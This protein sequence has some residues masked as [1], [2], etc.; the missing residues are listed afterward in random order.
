MKTIAFAA[1]TFVMGGAFLFSQDAALAKGPLDIE[2]D[3]PL[4]L[5][6]ETPTELDMSDFPFGL[7]EGT[8]KNVRMT[9]DQEMVI[10]DEDETF[11]MIYTITLPTLDVDK[12]GDDKVTIMFP[13][14][15]T[16]SMTTSAEGEDLQIDI[17]ATTDDQEMTFERDGERMNYS[18]TAGA[19]TL[20]LT[21]PQ[22]A[23]E[24]VDFE[25]TMG[26]KGLDVKGSGAAEQDWTDMKALDLSYDYTM[27]EITYDV[28]ATGEEP[29]QQFE[30]TGAAA[31]VSASGLVGQGRIE[32][33]TDASDMTIN[34]TKPLPIQA[35][36]GK[37]TSEIVMPTEPSPK[38]QD[39]KYVIAAEDVVLD[40]FLWSMMDPNNAFKRELNKIVIDLE[41]QAMMMVSLL[42]P[43]AM[44][45]A[46]MTGLPPMIPTGAKINSIA[47][48][49]L[50]L[51]VDATGEGELKG[52][53]P[54]GNAY[55]T[56]KGLSDFVG[57]AREAGMF[58]DQE[59]MMIEG[60]AGQLGKEGDDGELIF[61]I[62]TDGAMININGAPVMPIP[63]MQ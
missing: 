7:K 34:V 40:D 61:D 16:V 8:F 54:Q 13:E 57:G 22:A 42:D 12:D 63:S 47:F 62:E 29:D 24:G 21:S 52:T 41:M 27:D 31:S 44:A 55:I 59:A 9:F 14:E 15:Y 37:L 4:V 45:E 48:D 23:E 1:A 30:M 35:S 26:G 38:P 46:E 19:F 11:A 43:A 3:S 58:G 28:S 39:M 6:K 5:V 53:Q 17:L 32:G 2:V 18:G 50:G 20:K 49:G 51:V 10:P 56:V 33:S 25:F 60:M 36:I